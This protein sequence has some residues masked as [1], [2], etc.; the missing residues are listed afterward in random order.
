MTLTSS[1]RERS[2]HC[3]NPRLASIQFLG[4]DPTSYP[5]RYLG[6]VILETKMCLPGAF[7]GYALKDPV[8]NVNC[9]E[10]LRDNLQSSSYLG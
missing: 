10:K 3:Q 1:T 9:K 7:T 4:P 6:S 2:P 5:L 8:E